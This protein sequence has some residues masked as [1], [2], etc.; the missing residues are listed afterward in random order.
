MPT[1]E[2]RVEAEKDFVAKQSKASPIAAISELIWNSLDADAMTVS[3]ELNLDGLGGLSSITVHDDGTGFSL[4]AA[5]NG[6]GHLGGS[7]KRLATKTKKSGRFLHG[8][9]GRGR[10]KALSLGDLAIWTSDFE[11]GGVCQRFSVTISENDIEKAVLSELEPLSD[12]RTG[13]S[14]TIHNLKKTQYSITTDNAIQEFS[15]IFAIYL[16]DYPN[17]KIFIDGNLIDPSKVIENTIDFDLGMTLFE[18]SELPVKLELIEWKTNSS[19]HL[20]LCNH[21][22]FPL[23]KLDTRF[24]MGA[25]SFSAY[26]KSPLFD[27]L[28]NSNRIEVA[29]MLPEVKATIDVAKAKIKEC[30]R[31]KAAQKAQSW[32][33]KWKQAKIYPFEGNPTT[34]VEKAERQVFDIVAVTVQESSN[35]FS[36]L[37][38]KQTQLHLRM[39]KSAIEQSPEELQIILN[40]VLRLPSRK[41]KELANLLEFT[42][43]SGIISAVKVVSDRLNFLSGLTHILFDFEAKQK[44]KERSQL[45]KILEQNA[46]LFGEE[47]NLWASDKELTTLLK[48]YA[49]RLG[50]EISIGEKVKIIDKSKGIIDL[51]FSRVMRRHRANDMEN[52]VVEIKAPKVKLNSEHISQIEKY[53]FA[54]NDD[55]RF[56]G[57][58]GVKWHFWLIS[59]S[60]DDHVKRR[61]EGGP[62]SKRRLIIKDNRYEIGIKTWGEI[63]EENRSRLQFLKENLEHNA[64]EEQV[65]SFL[66]ANYASFV[67][68]VLTKNPTETLQ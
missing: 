34:A 44:L 10:F 46:W 7:W 58:E 16:K 35:E 25:Y 54:I 53:A 41:Q 31:E 47:F 14:L 29:E 13:T 59:D 57:I 63:I 21:L 51:M 11:S 33:D 45:H 37:T 4:E 65:S 49:D 30:Y 19:R 38:P 2:L 55:D 15:E 56:S 36:E 9:E 52:L 68:G 28:Y 24:Q 50:K 39:L 23:A 26:L 60:Y 62:D 64:S 1:T 22:G 18:E 17:I 27:E 42:N 66:Q 43:L 48:V 40:E 3:V 61:I 32:V 8:K 6:F 20:H 67:E 5:K 12:L